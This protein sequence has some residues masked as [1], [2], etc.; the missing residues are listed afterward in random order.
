MNAITLSALA[1]L[2]TSAAA[3]PIVPS[4]HHKVTVSQ[5]PSFASTDLRAAGDRRGRHLLRAVIISRNKP[6]ITIVGAGHNSS[7][8]QFNMSSHASG[9]SVTPTTFQVNA[10]D[11]NALGMTFMNTST[12]VFLGAAGARLAGPSPA[13]FTSGQRTGVYDSWI[14]GW[15]DTLLTNAGQAFYENNW[16]ESGE[17]IWNIGICPWLTREGEGRRL[18]LGHR[19]HR[20]LPQLHLEHPPQRRI[21][22]RRR[23]RCPAQRREPPPDQLLKS[24]FGGYVLEN[25]TLTAPEGVTNWFLGRPWGTGATALYVDCV[26]PDSVDPAYWHTMTAGAT[27]V[28]STI[29]CTGPGA[30]SD[31]ID[32]SLS[33][34]VTSEQAEVSL[35]LDS[36]LPGASSWIQDANRFNNRKLRGGSGCVV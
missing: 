30:N 11:F 8:V 3:T 5:T 20:L 1:L 22:H 15:Q 24:T 9:N 13:L 31:S 21:R 28:Y 18:H 25:Y 16:I 33:V 10:D 14:L 17:L 36:W 23:Y 6:F 19:G 27:P 26:I 12:E 7:V 2:A 4:H 29:N 34:V 32:T 35:T